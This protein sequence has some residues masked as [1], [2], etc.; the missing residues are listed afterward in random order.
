VIPDYFV[1]PVA[2]NSLLMSRCSMRIFQPKEDEVTR[3]EKIN[4]DLKKLLLCPA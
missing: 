2:A 4:D 3:M 1:P